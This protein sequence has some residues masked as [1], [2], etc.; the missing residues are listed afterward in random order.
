MLQSCHERPHEQKK[1]LRSI[2]LTGVYPSI[3]LATYNHIGNRPC[4]C[5]DN[6]ANN[7]HNALRTLRWVMVFERHTQLEYTK[8][9]DSKT[10]STK[11]A[12]DKVCG[13]VNRSD[14]I[15]VCSKNCNN[16]DC[17]HQGGSNQRIEKFR[18]SFI[19]LS[20]FNRQYRFFHCCFP[21]SENYL[22]LRCEA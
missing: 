3:F 5:N 7:S 4:H 16:A 8:R 15:T 21:L 17:S 20:H 6:P 13:S 22:L 2:M 9:K 14:R 19:L 1:Q 12:K 10:S 18:N 11:D